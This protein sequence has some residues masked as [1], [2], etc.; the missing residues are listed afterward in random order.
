MIEGKLFNLIVDNPTAY[1]IR[2][3]EM[4]EIRNKTKMPSI[5]ISSQHCTVGPS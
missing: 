4:F 2:N 3:G 5:T 1:T